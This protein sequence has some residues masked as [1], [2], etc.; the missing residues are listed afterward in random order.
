MRK[1]ETRRLKYPLENHVGSSWQC[2]DATLGPPDLPTL[3]HPCLSRT[4]TE[5]CVKVWDHGAVKALSC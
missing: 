2:Q 1:E 5:H 4:F 3:Q